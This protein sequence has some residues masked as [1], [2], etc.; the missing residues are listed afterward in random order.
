MWPSLETCWAPAAENG[1]T[2][3]DTWASGPRA[4]TILAVRSCTEAAVIEPGDVITTWAGLPDWFGKAWSRMCCTGWEPPERLLEKLLPAICAPTF[5]PTSPTSQMIKTHHRW[6]W[7]QPA[8]RARPLSSACCDRGRS[9]G[10]A[11][12]VTVVVAMGRN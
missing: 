4:A 1:L 10:P 6:S 12:D 2:T 7:H 8:M 3:S 11:G 9:V 5:I